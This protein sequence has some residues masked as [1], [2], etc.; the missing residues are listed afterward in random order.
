MLVTITLQWT[1]T[2][3][4]ESLLSHESID[5]MMLQDR[6]DQI[7]KVFLQCSTLLA[8]LLRSFLDK[9]GKRKRLCRHLQVPFDL[10]IIQLFG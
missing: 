9:S 6:F 10:S 5:L 7:L 2:T 8:E 1:T 3:W 4:A